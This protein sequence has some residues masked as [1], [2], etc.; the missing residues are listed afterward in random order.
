MYA[1]PPRQIPRQAKMHGYEG[2]IDLG[3]AER[4][5]MAIDEDQAEAFVAMLDAPP[6]PS[7]ALIEL[8]RPDPAHIVAVA[9]TNWRGERGIRRIIPRRIH[10][11]SNQWH[12]DAQWLIDALDCDK[13]EE[14]TFA[15]LGVHGCRAGADAEALIGEPMDTVFQAFECV[16]A[17]YGRLIRAGFG[18]PEGTPKDEA[19]LWDQDKALDELFNYVERLELRAGAPRPESRIW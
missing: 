4:H 18:P 8:M 5:V 12:K 16:Q 3:P 14:R 17:L 13:G 9:Y 11:G 2:G 19:N 1:S 15:L 7:P 10:W 6:N